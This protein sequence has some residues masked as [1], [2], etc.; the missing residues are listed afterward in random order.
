MPRRPDIEAGLNAEI[1]HLL[2]LSAQTFRNGAQAES[3]AL[4]LQAWALIPEPKQQCN[5][6]TTRKACLQAA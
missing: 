6:M 3:L 2:V 1:D 5:G 4:R